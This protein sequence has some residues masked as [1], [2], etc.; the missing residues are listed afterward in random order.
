M[1]KFYNNRILT[2]FM[3]IQPLIDII[4]SLMINEYNFHISLGMICRFIFLI[5]AGIYIIKNRDSKINTYIIIWIIYLLTSLVG[6]FLLDSH[7]NIMSFGVNMAKLIYFPIILLFFTLY[8]KKNEE[9]DRFTF[10]II[11]LIIGISLL[12]S[13]ITKT[14][15]C[16]YSSYENCYHKGIVSWF[17]SANEYGLILISLLGYSLIDF[18]KNKNIYNITASLFTIV[19]LCIL[20]TKASYV[21]CVGVLSISLIFYIIY[22]KFI[23]KNKFDFKSVFFIGGILLSVLIFTIKLPIYTNLLGSYERAV[24]E[25]GQAKCETCCP[26]FDKSAE[27]IKSEISNALVFNGRNE[28]LV[29]NKEMYNNSSIFSKLYGLISDDKYYQGIYYDHIVERDFHDL[30][31]QYG[32]IGF[33]VEL[34]LPIYL[35]INVIVKFVK[36]KKIIIDEEIFILGLTSTFILLGSYLA[37]H[38]LFA[39]AVSIYVAYSI[40]IIYK[41]VMYS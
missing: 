25:S 17:N 28:F 9:L 18:I 20:G 4:T 7:F 33:L 38:F 15:Y 39:P 13:I 21:G 34:L 8:F 30:L 41:R 16:S 23:K 31:Y 29:V 1:D 11:A 40:S 6:H 26:K 37:G 22:N 10:I 3:L 27:E 32:F 14:A 24:N 19:F 36:T 35:V 5:Y 2:K 12:T